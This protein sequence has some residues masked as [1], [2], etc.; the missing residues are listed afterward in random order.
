M[1]LS[2]LKRFAEAKTVF[3][4]WQE[5]LIQSKQKANVQVRRGNK[6]KLKGIQGRKWAYGEC[7]CIGGIGRVE[8]SV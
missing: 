7:N 5:Q 3:D 4:A 6:E 8:R 2:A 1:C